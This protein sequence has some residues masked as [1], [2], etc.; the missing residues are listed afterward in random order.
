MVDLNEKPPLPQPLPPWV[1]PA[2]QDRQISKGRLDAATD[3]AALIQ[4]V[5][6]LRWDHGD[7]VPLKKMKNQDG[8]M[9]SMDEIY[10]DLL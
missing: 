5:Q 2:E 9:D 10:I 8:V 3:A 6:Q 1:D 4:G 7:L